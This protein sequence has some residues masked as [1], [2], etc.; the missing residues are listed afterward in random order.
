MIPTEVAASTVLI[1]PT[2]NKP[3]LLKACLAA[4]KKHTRGAYRVVIADD[5]S[6]DADMQGYLTRLEG[7]GYTV[8]KNGSGTRGFPHNVNWAVKDTTEPFICLV[9]QDIEVTKGWL[10]ALKAEM[11][12][13]RAGIIGCLLLYPNNK[14]FGRPGLVQHAGVAINAR[15]QPSHMFRLADK[16]DPRVQVRRDWINAVTFALVLIRRTTWD[17]VGG[18]DERYVGGQFED[19][20]MCLAARARG[21]KV[22]YTPGAVAYHYEH[23]SGEEF[24]RETSS[25]NMGRFIA[26]WGRLPS[27]EWLYSDEHV[28]AGKEGLVDAV[29]RQLWPVY[30]DG[31]SVIG[32]NPTRE[33]VEAGRQLMRKSWDTIGSERQER[34]R[35]W[36]RKIMLARVE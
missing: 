11:R 31:L 10:P 2:Y 18:L 17:D 16:D 19:I 20:H 15:G 4:I 35:A 32:A 28:L 33:V 8:V 7:E 6:P 5:N 12:D 27:D 30:L 26:Y 3:G 22:V 23:G 21:W 13:A 14:G 29:A 1:I 34:L 36:A 9:N 25:V 24:C